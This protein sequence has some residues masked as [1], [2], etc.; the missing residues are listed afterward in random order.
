MK[1]LSGK[2]HATQNNQ[3]LIINVI[4]NTIAQII[5]GSHIFY[6]GFP[7]FKC[8]LPAYRKCRFRYLAI[9]LCHSSLLT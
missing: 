6:C 1:L 5:V 3:M 4:F 9:S 7:P 2:L 8:E